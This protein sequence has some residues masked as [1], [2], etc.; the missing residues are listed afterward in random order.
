M[1]I[2][3]MWRPATGVWRNGDPHVGKVVQGKA[4]LFFQDPPYM[5]LWF[6]SFMRLLL[7]GIDCF[8]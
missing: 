1:P 5:G 8:S 3:L 2:A 7:H 6:N 4:R